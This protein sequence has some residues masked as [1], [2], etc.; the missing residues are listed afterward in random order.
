MAVCGDTHR[1]PDLGVSET[2]VQAHPVPL[3]LSP[4]GRSLNLHALQSPHPTE[5]DSN[6]D[7]RKPVWRMKS[8]WKSSC[9]SQTRFAKKAASYYLC[10]NIT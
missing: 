3:R 6:E 8:G 9:S 1:L 7:L 4:V 10:A 5:G 2:Q